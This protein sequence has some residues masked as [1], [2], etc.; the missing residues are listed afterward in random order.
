V[1][2]AEGLQAF[3][4]PRVFQ[5]EIQEA[6]DMTPEEL[7]QAARDLI[8][9]SGSHMRS[10]SDSPPPQYYSQLG[11][12]QDFEQGGYQAQD[13]EPAQEELQDYRSYSD[14]E[15]SHVTHRH[16]S[17]SHP[18]HRRGQRGGDDDDDVVHATTTL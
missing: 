1:L 3:V 17:L 13:Y 4:D 8:R 7:D 6:T 14:P 16:R 11:F 2:Q 9:R 10:G 15:E 18:H 5:R 12:P